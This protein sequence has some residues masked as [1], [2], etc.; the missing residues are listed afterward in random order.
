MPCLNT[1][2]PGKAFFPASFF[3][4]LVANGTDV[5]QNGIQ[6][7]SGLYGYKDDGTLGAGYSYNVCD[8]KYYFV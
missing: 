5:W 6:W 2:G 3:L 7:I 4:Y 8:K 1:L